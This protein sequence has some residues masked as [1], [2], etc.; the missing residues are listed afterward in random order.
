M[1]IPVVGLIACALTG[2]C[3]SM[4]W[5]GSLV[6]ASEKFPESGV[7]I[8][9][10]M[11]AGGDLGAAI[12]PQLVGA[13]ADGVVANPAFTSLVETLSISLEQLGLRVGV[14]CGALFPL[15]AILIF[16]LHLRAHNKDSNPKLLSEKM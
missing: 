12:G 2:L 6:I 4:M 7:F 9:A 11:A 16:G 14:L 8:Y 1:P 15:L 13:V 5:P 3:T 10:M